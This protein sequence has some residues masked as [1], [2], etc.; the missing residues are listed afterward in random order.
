MATSY[1]NVKKWR[2][3]TKLRLVEA[4]GNECGVCGYNKSISSLC[5][6]HLDPIGKETI[7]SSICKSW[8]VTVE[9]A[10]KCVMLCMNCH[11]EVHVGMTKIPESIMRFDESFAEY[12]T[13]RKDMIDECPVCGKEKPIFQNT[14]SKLC[15]AKI[16]H[17]IDWDN[18]DLLKLYEET[19][20][21]IGV[22]SKLGVSDS[23]IRKR[24][25]RLKENIGDW[26]T[27]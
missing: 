3:N 9:E 27:G 6:H 10:R 2:Q 22:A 20:T 12:K 7:L 24:I 26:S 17:K 14:C 5:F 16:R 4:F 21:Y 15:G 19:G 11:G 18:I 13:L 1:K 25:L 8:K 23:L